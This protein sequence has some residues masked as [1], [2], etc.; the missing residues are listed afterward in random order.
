MF[1]CSLVIDETINDFFIGGRYMRGISG[2]WSFV[3]RADVGAGDSDL[4]WNA[5]VAF[6]YQFTKLLSGVAGWRALD[7]DVNTGSGADTFKYDMNHSGPLLALAF[8]W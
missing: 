7:Y 8:H 1:G 2:K 5:L 4:V 6:D 3:G